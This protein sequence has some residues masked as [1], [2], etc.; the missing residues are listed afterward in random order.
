MSSPL[1]A[2]PAAREGLRGESELRPSSTRPLPLGGFRLT[3]E[4][5]WR[6]Y[7]PSEPQK[8]LRMDFSGE[9]QLTLKPKRTHSTSIQGLVLVEG[10]ADGTPMSGT[11]SVKLPLV[12]FDLAVR[13]TDARG[14]QCSIDAS[15]RSVL[16]AAA[17]Y[18]S[19]KGVLKRGEMQIGEIDLQVDWNVVKKAMPS[20]S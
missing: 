15:T 14:D 13:F 5:T 6:G 3:I 9:W 8:K 11:L 18:T 16:N 12:G 10:I 4:G 17:R 7:R 19:V 2:S 20:L 1:M